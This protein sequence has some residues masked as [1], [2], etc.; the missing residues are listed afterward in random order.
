MKRLARGPGGTAEHP[1]EAGLPDGLHQRA[2]NAPRLLMQI[3]RQVMDGR[4]YFVMDGMALPVGRTAQGDEDELMPC[5]FEAQQFLRNERFR[6]AW[7][8]LQHDGDLRFR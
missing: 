8:T 7:I 3:F 5:S 1:P 6:K 4:A 2:E